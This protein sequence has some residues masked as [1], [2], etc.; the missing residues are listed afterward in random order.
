M[1]KVSIRYGCESCEKNYEVPVT[2][3][4]LRHNEELAAFFGWSDNIRL[5][6]NGVEMSDEVVVPSGSLVVVETKANKKGN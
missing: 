6:I 5:L 2:I 1:Q 4:F 3:G